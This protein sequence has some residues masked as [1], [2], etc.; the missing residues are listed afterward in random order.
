MLCIYMYIY[1][2][3]YI[4]ILSPPQLSSD[5]VAGFARRLV[6]VAPHLPPDAALALLSQV[7]R[8]PPAHAHTRTDTSIPSLPLP[9]GPPPLPPP[10]Y[11]PAP[12][13]VGCRRRRALGR[14]P[15]AAAGAGKPG[16]LQAYCRLIAGLLQA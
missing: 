8:P 4:C 7:Y 2:L 11:A 3:F 15:S 12:P 13:R 1:I 6:A 14:R 5:R 10:A 9:G 16:L